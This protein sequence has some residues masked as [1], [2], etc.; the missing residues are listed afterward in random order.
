MN[1][2]LSRDPQQSP[3]LYTQMCS[4]A[5]SESSTSFYH[6][7]RLSPFTYLTLLLLQVLFRLLSIAWEASAP[8]AVEDWE[9]VL[10]VIYWPVMIG[11]YVILR[12]FMITSK[13]KYWLEY[14]KLL[15]SSLRIVITS[16]SPPTPLLHNDYLIAIHFHA[17]IDTLGLV[18]NGK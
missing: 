5:A 11:G 2:L 3:R 8:L 13:S 6:G 18:K 15:V 10:L 4:T 17:R 16:L 12:T 7:S 9:A 14:I 1:V